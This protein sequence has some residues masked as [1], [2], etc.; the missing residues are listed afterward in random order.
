MVVLK[1]ARWM[2][3]NLAD[4]MEIEGPQRDGRYQ[5]DMSSKNPRFTRKIT[6]NDQLGDL[7]HERSDRPDLSS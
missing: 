1:I 3:Q 6:W 4:L 5:I 2:A 7:R